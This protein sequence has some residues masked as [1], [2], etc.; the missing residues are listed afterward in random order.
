MRFLKKYP[1]PTL[2]IVLTILGLFYTILL[3]SPRASQLKGIFAN[4]QFQLNSTDL[5]SQPL[6]F[7]SSQAS[8][9]FNQHLSSSTP[10]AHTRFLF[11]PNTTTIITYATFNN[12]PGLYTLELVSDQQNQVQLQAAWYGQI[13]LSSN[14]RTSLQNQL[15][16]LLQ[17][18]YYSTQISK[19]HIDNNHVIL[20]LVPA[21]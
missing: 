7:T 18:T 8:S 13:P 16:S 9:L 3:T 17:Q 15:N 19:F 6:R 4:Q 10:L 2:I 20:D 11:D 5:Y 1:Y 12:L 14:L 21:D